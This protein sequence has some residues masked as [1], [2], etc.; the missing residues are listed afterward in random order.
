MQMTWL[1]DTCPSTSV[2][3]PKAQEM[4]AD[5]SGASLTTRLSCGRRIELRRPGLQA[6]LCARTYCSLISPDI[7][8]KRRALV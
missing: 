6:R 5:K 3:F 4:P 8:Y 1:P 2:R 7:I